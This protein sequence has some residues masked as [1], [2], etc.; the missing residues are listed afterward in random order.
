[1]TFL[2]EWLRY[3]VYRWAALGLLASYGLFVL[4]ATAVEAVLARRRN[5]RAREPEIVPLVF[6]PTPV[7]SVTTGT[8]GL[9]P[10]GDR[11]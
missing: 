2:T 10:R 8:P 11:P 5:R 4:I 6:A 1:M 7:I 9:S 3:P